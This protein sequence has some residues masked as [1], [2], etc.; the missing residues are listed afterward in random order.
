MPADASSLRRAILT[1]ALLGSVSGVILLATWCWYAQW[2]ELQSESLATARDRLEQTLARAASLPAKA[3][4]SYDAYRADF[5][6]G[7]KDALIIAEQQ[8]RLR[9]VVMQHGSELSSASSLPPKIIDGQVYLGLRLQ[10]RGRINDVQAI[11]YAIEYE[12]PYLFTDRVDLHLESEGGPFASQSATKDAMLFV[13]I[14]VYGE[15]W[16]LA[17]R[18]SPATPLSPAGVETP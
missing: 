18:R 3:S 9:G 17:D 12:K 6:L 13:D 14:D 4:Q 16:P 1:V 11:L 5:L 15:K 7:E 2:Q 10:L 8:T